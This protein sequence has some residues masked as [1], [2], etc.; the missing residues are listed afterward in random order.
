[1]DLLL[2]TAAF[3]SIPSIHSL[4]SSNVPPSMLKQSVDNVRLWLGVAFGTFQ[5]RILYVLLLRFQ[6]VICLPTHSIKLCAGPIA[7]LDRF[8]LAVRGRAGL[9]AIIL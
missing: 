5:F 8:E 2:A 6:T 1:M 4:L 3:T 7:G 9:E